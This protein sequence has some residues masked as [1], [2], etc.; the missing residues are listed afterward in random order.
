[1]LIIEVDVAG[2]E[3]AGVPAPRYDARLVRGVQDVPA[4]HSRQPS[5]GEVTAALILR[6]V[7]P[8]RVVSCVRAATRGGGSISPEL[9]GQLLPAGAGTRPD[10]SQPQLTDREYDVLRM[11][12]DGEST[13]GIAERLSYSER[14]VKNIVHDLLVKLGCRTRAHAVALATRQGVI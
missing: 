11:L 6:D 3:S 1:M 10:P 13:R 4:G 8:S 2:S 9:L 5:G 12:A 14:T 7:A